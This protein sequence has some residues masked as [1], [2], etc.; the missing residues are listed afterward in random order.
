MSWDDATAWQAIASR[1]PIAVVEDHLFHVTELLEALDAEAPELLAHT[2]VLCLERAGPDTTVAVE[3]WLATWPGLRVAAA[4]PA[5][6]AGTPG[7]ALDPQVFTLPQ[8]FC[9]ALAGMLRP[10]GLLLQDIQLSTL[11]FIPAERWWESIYLAA[12]V[13]GMFPSRPPACR[14]FSNKRGYEATFGRDLAEAGFDPRDV[15][16][17]GDLEQVLVPTVRAFLARR[18]PWDLA[19]AAAGPPVAL[20]VSEEDRRE[21]EGALD[22]VAWAAADGGLDL[23]G[24]M[25]AE[26][27]RLHLRHG[28][29][30]GETWRALIA[31]RL[32]GGAGLAVVDVGARIA[33]LGALRAEAT[34]AA[35][36]HLHL[37]RSRLADPAVLVTANHAYRLR[38]DVTAGLA[39]AR[40]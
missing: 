25:L 15:I 11:A 5:A 34:N 38:D 28:S 27:K 18:F 21:A 2:A 37:L 29:P 13:R 35:A 22:L 9:R 24:R 1:R 14:F 40:T 36:R 17:K 3:R 19:T 4:V 20:G 7:T 33:P 12:T 16:E 26:G 39:R 23:G 30:E 10:G 6:L 8:A 31:D 32:A